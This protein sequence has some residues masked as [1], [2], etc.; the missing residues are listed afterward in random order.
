MPCP[1]ATPDRFLPVAGALL[2]Y[3]DEG[4]GPAV[5]LIHGWTLDLE[6]WEPQ[7]AALA[8]AFRLI[9]LDRRGFGLSSGR[10]SLGADVQDALCLC[11]SLRLDRI[12]CVGMSQGAR[13]ALHLCRLAPQRLCCVVLDGPPRMDAQARAEKATQGP[14]VPLAEYRDLLAR[15]DLEAFRRRWLSHPLMQL[16]TPSRESRALLERMTARYGGDDLRQQPSVPEDHWD[17]AA[18]AAIRTP[19]L[20]ITGAHD[21]PAR[22]RAADALAESLA[23]AQRAIIPGARHLPNLDNP[24][25]YD[26]TLRAFLERHAGPRH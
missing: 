12:A 11:D 22:V 1:S 13:V 5:L 6:M 26:A 20:V 4:S 18:F 17:R 2:R 8:G 7:V 14:D 3:R 15:G 19:A 10:A 16:Q 9:R 24:L 25:S 23:H 21:L